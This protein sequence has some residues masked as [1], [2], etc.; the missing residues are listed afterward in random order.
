MTILVVDDEPEVG[1]VLAELLMSDGHAV[2]TAA[3]GMRALQRLAQ[4]SYDLILCDLTMPV[5]DGPG[6]YREVE[7]RHPELLSRFIFLTGDVLRQE[8]KAFL[9]RAGRP[10]FSKPYGLGEIRQAVRRLCRAG[11]EGRRPT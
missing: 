10:S 5:L 1:G 8:T 11:V 2:D 3:D 9:E 4:Q 6:L 7:R